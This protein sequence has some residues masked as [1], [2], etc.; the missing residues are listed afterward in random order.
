MDWPKRIV[1]VLEKYYNLQEKSA[2]YLSD[3]QK[4]LFVSDLIR[5]YNSLDYTEKID[6]VIPAK[7][8]FL[9]KRAIVVD[10][11]SNNKI[12]YDIIYKWPPNNGFDGNTENVVLKNGQV[13]DRI[14]SNE[15]R[16]ISPLSKNGVPLSYLE[17]ALPYY[18][19]EANIVD[20]PAYHRYKIKTDYSGNGKHKVIQ[21]KIAQA[22][23]TAPDDGG[24][25]QVCLPEFV[26]NL[27]M[28]F[29]DA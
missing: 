20:S 6:V 14:G 22:F 7:Q 21:G 27:R 29:A 2:G 17:R 18:I 5:I 28:V 3:A 25:I 8:E 9:A 24:G 10:R 15:G 26:C 1:E 11:L 13:Y 4:T 19:P 12:H 16:Y 23:W